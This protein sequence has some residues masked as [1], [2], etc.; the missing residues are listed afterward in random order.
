MAEEIALDPLAPEN[1]HL[2]LSAIEE[3]L[4]EK[5]MDTPPNEYIDDQGRKWRDGKLVCEMSLN[6]IIREKAEL[7]P[8]RF[9]IVMPGA[10]KPTST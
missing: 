1:R 10:N 2:W 3:I 8:H 5:I 9:K 4:G 7:K 6:E